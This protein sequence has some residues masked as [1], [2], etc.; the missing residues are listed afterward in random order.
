MPSLEPCAL[1]GPQLGFRLEDCITEPVGLL[2]AD[3]VEAGLRREGI[4]LLEG[5]RVTVPLQE[6][7][8]RRD[9]SK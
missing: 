9:P 3:E 5:S 1:R 8:H 6:V 2:L 4:E 7:L